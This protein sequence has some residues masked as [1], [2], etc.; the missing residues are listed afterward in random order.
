MQSDKMGY[1][2][3]WCRYNAVQSDAGTKG[4]RDL[5]KSGKRVMGERG[6]EKENG[7][8]LRKDISGSLR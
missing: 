8:K 5:K 4:V 3:F 7:R 2:Q 1:K 6:R